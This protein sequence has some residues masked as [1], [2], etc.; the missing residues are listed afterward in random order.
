MGG[1]EVKTF[2]SEFDLAGKI[3][4]FALESFGPEDP[5]EGLDSTP[6]DENGCVL[7]PL[8]KPVA[9][10]RLK[11]KETE[12][13]PEPESE[14]DLQERIARLER[15]AYEKGFA[16]GQ[17]DGRDLEGRQLK[18]MTKHLDTLLD[19]LG[20]LKEQIYKETEKEMVRLSVAIAEK[21]TRSELRAGSYH[22]EETIRAAMRFLVDTSHV[23]IRISPEDMEDVSKLV[24]SVAVDT[25]AGRI[26]IME[27]HAVQRG[28]CVLQTG[29]G[30]VNATV[31]D[32][33][34]MVVKEIERV[35]NSEGKTS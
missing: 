31:E 17:K 15:E 27:D 35:L 8:K 18:E 29:F 34:A 28:G 22:I 2:L 6:L 25:K 26:E 9:R 33:M 14:E 13:P 16:Q 4:S 23:R 3:P 11:E 1:R 19:A 32:Q 24:P 21:I 7:L 12:K 5:E 10:S 20:G 30:N